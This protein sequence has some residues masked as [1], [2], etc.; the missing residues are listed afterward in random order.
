MAKTDSEKL[1]D[2]FKKDSQWKSEYKKLR[3]IVKSLKLKEERKWMHP[4]Y[5]LDNKNIVLIHGFKNF[6]ALL[7]FKGALMND[8]K[9]ILVQQTE[10]VQAGRQIRFTSIKEIEKLES[11]IKT[12]IKEAIRVEESGEK[13]ELKKTEDYEVPDE[14]EEMFEEIPNFR[15]AFESLTPGRQRG[16]L[17]HFAQ[18]KQPKT[19]I[20]RIEKNIDKIMEGIGLNDDYIQSKKKK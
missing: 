1:E 3:Q 20:A 12:Y 5:T 11:T 4:C 6:C 8:P 15:D 13:L 2:F 18:A 7:F 9:N 16:Y 10:N 17:L 19:R 14:L